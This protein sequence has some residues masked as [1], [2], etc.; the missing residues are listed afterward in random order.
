MKK[1]LIFDPYLDTLGGGERYVLSFASCLADLGY[2]AQLAW[3]DPEILHDAGKRFGQSYANLSVS[4]EAYLNCTKAQSLYQKFL[5]Q[6]D[7]D[8]IFWVSDGSIPF[9][10][11]KQ[12]LLHLQVPF[13][14]FGKTD[15][16]SKVKQLFISKYVCNSKFTKNVYASTLALKKLAVLYPPVDTQKMSSAKKEKWI[17]SV[18]RFDSPMHHKRQDILIEAFKKLHA[19]HADYKLL[20]AGGSKDPA[21]ISDL[22]KKA[23]GLPVEFILNPSFPVLHELYSKSRFFW[24]AA[25]FEIDEVKNPEKVEHFGITTVEAMGASCIPVVIKKGG[26]KEIIKHSVNGYLCDD[27]NQLV[28]FTNHLIDSP[29]LRVKIKKQAKIDATE[30]SLETFKKTLEKLLS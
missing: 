26:Q 7:Y 6:K 14:N 18:A 10:F 27:V 3:Y 20:L 12:N 11:G 1:A 2:S 5:F 4:Q 8:L 16:L 29:K 28:D 24:H 22:I 13:T 23:K 19:S 17:I 15:P 30:F 25:G 21:T 9:L